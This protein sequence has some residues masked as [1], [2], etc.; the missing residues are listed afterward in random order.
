MGLCLHAMA[1]ELS[2]T[3]CG[4]SVSSYKVLT[5]PPGEIHFSANS[6]EI[7]KEQKITLNGH[8]EILTPQLQLQSDNAQFDTKDQLL[9]SSGKLTVKHEEF[10]FSGDS[11]V[12]NLKNKEGSARNTTYQINNSQGHGSAQTIEFHNGKLDLKKAEYTT[13][14]PERVSSRLTPMPSGKRSLE[15]QCP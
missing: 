3:Q 1:D 8:V 15:N 12:I 13:C 10:Q 11:L 9:K 7:F 14:P 5:S 2:D 4:P 6:L